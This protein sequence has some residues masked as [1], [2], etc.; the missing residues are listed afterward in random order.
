M[1]APLSDVL[2]VN[3]LLYLVK[4]FFTRIKEIIYYLGEAAKMS[5]A[6]NIKKLRMI[7]D[8]TQR[9][10]AEVAGVTENAVSKWENG[11]AEP[12]MGAIEKM[13][14]CYNLS[15]MH[16]IEDGGMD[17][18]DPATKKPYPPSASLPDG[19][20]MPAPSPKATAPLYGDVH[21]GVPTDED[22]AYA[23]VEL[24][25]EVAERHPAAY[26][27]RVDGDCMDKVYPE[28]C[29]VLVDPTLGCENGRIMCLEV[30]GVGNIMRRVYRS[31]RTLLLV[32]ESNNPEHEDIVLSA[33]DAVVR[34]LGRVVWFQSAGEL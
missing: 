25:A 8:V 34:S 16:I 32:P 3:K 10:L 22:V 15:K 26:F 2:T 28:G 19:A 13:A 11:Y 9:E 33:D 12:R 14:A 27:L 20:F 17:L 23:V 7:F 1:L 24:P 30:E 5:V 6:E 29:M 21:A 31:A 18:I 4:K